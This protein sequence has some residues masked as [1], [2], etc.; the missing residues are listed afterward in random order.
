MTRCRR[1]HNYSRRER[2]QAITN[3]RAVVSA[4][5]VRGKRAREEERER[6]RERERES[7]L[8][9]GTIKKVTMEQIKPSVC[10]YVFAY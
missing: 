3:A 10:M 1:S 4:T 8:M 2:A 9:S 7:T 6:E 5:A